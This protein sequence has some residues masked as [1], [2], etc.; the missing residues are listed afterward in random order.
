LALEGRQLTLE[1]I[2]MAVLVE[3]LFSQPLHQLVEV[4]VGLEVV[5]QLLL[6]AVLVEVVVMAQQHLMI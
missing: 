3:I 2:P 5:V 1:A 4:A 6:Q